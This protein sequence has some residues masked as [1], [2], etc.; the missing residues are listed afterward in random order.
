MVGGD[1]EGE[2][3]DC[4]GHYCSLLQDWVDL[5]GVDPSEIKAQCRKL[6]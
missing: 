4:D 1:S 5:K 2:G 6:Q 3:K